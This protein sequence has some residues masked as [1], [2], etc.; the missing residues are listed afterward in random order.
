[1]NLVR[2]FLQKQALFSIFFQNVFNSYTKAMQSMGYK[3]QSK[4]DYYCTYGWYSWVVE[5]FFSNH[6]LCSYKKYSVKIKLYGKLL[7]KKGIS[8]FT[9]V[10]NQTKAVTNFKRVL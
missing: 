7:F 1:M 9:L 10:L 8:I 2:L 4:W 3:Y 5:F 6:C